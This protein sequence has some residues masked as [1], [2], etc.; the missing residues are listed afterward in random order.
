MLTLQVDFGPGGEDSGAHFDWGW[1]A[2]VGR[3]KQTKLLRS[4]DAET[5][6]RTTLSFFSAKSLRVS[7]VRF[8]FTPRRNQSG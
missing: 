7:A 4:R 5:A 8:L 6:Q 1:V 3:K 2:V